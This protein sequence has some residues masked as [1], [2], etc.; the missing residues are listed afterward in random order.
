MIAS[1]VLA[2][3][4]SSRMG[5]PKMLLPWGAG[6]VLSASVGAHLEAG[7]DLVVV[8]LGPGGEEVWRGSGLHPDPR[9]RSVVNEAWRE[10]LASSLRRGL[11]ECGE[12]TAVLVALGDQPGVTASR[13][14]RIVE[15]WQ[16]GTRLV[17]PVQGQRAGH[18]V[19]FDRSLWDELLALSGDAG[20]REVVRRHWGEAVTVEAEPL[21]D[22][23]TEEDYQ[24]LREGRGSRSPAGWKVPPS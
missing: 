23:D 10:G 3:G 17:V 4:A 16:P 13:I 6:T 8:V 22:I 15:A 9:L 18:P 12:A 19:L 7:V 11:E 1:V 24:A 2:G 21:F 5:R 20:A 14:R